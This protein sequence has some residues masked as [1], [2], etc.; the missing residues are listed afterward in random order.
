ML[1]WHFSS[2]KTANQLCSN[3]L[4]SNLYKSFASIDNVYKPHLGF[5]CSRLGNKG[6]LE[7]RTSR[8]WSSRG[9][10]QGRGIVSYIWGTAATAGDEMPQIPCLLVSNALKRP[11]MLLRG[12]RNAPE[13]ICNIVKPNKFDNHSCPCKTTS[14]H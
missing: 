9:P 7:R 11:R 13:L 14:R 8:G 12:Q 2:D 6:S 1:D 4:K 10:L 3:R 5:I